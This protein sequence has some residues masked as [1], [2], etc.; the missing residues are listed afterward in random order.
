MKSYEPNFLRWGFLVLFLI[1]TISICAQEAPVKEAPL[2]NMRYESWRNSSPEDTVVYKLKSESEEPEILEI[3]I[4]EIKLDR[5]DFQMRTY[6]KERLIEEKR[7]TISL[8]DME[9]YYKPLELKDKGI[10]IT[11]LRETIM[12]SVYACQRFQYADGSIEIYCDKIP[13][14]GLYKKIDSGGETISEL[15]ETRQG[16]KRTS[17]VTELDEKKVKTVEIKTGA[18]TVSELMTGLKEDRA[19]IQQSIKEGKRVVIGNVGKQPVEE[20]S[21]AETFLEEVKLQNGKVSDKFFKYGPV[22]VVGFDRPKASA[23]FHMIETVEPGS[24][25]SPPA[26]LEINITYTDYIPPKNKGYGWALFTLF[27]GD[28]VTTTQVRLKE[29]PFPD[30]M[31]FELPPESVS[32]IPGSFDC[33]HIRLVSP[34]PEVSVTKQD[35]F[36]VTTIRDV[37]IDYWISNVEEST[38]AVKKTLTEREQIIKSTLDEN[39][40]VPE[41]IDRS[42]VKKWTLVE[43]KP[44]AK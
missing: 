18:L 13:A 32:I 29:N 30:M 23:K 1:G 43:F 25:E 9:R 6:L 12:G 16:S 26:P 14:G 42:R 10:E 38:V 15:L 11:E 28:E 40:E 21:R 36:Q 22:L 4:I 34:K 8:K 24:G 44:S 31:A 7:E 20:S 5:Y 27:V 35:R 33:Y 17:M 37:K 41:K 2:V 3:K 19:K 39:V